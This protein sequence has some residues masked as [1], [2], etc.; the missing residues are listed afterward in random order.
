MTEKLD[1]LIDRFSRK[2]EVVIDIDGTCNND[3]ILEQVL[4]YTVRLNRDV[5]HKVALVTLGSTS[6]F[7][8]LTNNSNKFYYYNGTVTR[9]LTIPSGS[10]EI[11]DYNDRVK[12]SIKIQ[13]DNSDNITITLDHATGKTEIEL[14]ASYKVNFNREKAW[15][16]C[17]G[18]EAVYLETDGLHT[19]NYIAEVLPTQM[20]YMS[21]DICK[22]SIGNRDKRIRSNTIFSFPNNK[23][24]GS[25]FVLTP[26]PLRPR[27]V[28]LKEFDTIR[29]QFTDDDGNPV[30]FLGA[31]VTGELYIYQA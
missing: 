28:L 6:F 13:G 4:P 2:E 27:E 9:I 17:L 7:P 5:T 15:R 21:C 3:G 29:L 12:K 14:K 23:A 8:N 26:N 10:Y 31:Q 30:S 19:S 16:D 25:P 22:G 24:F 11:K 20:I 1:T 18:F